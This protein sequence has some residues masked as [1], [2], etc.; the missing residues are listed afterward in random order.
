MPA[1]RLLTNN[2]DKTTSLESYG[3]TVAET[4]PLAIHPTEDNIGYLRTKRDR[5][6]HLLPNLPDEMT[7]QAMTEEL[8][9]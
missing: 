8:H 6:G 9:Q 2:P 3:V 7:P 1:I 5:M 4:V